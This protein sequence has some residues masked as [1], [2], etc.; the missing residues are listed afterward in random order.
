MAGMNI[1]FS[2]I[3]YVSLIG[4]SEIVSDRSSCYLSRAQFSLLLTCEDAL[5][6]Q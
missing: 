4:F 1:I 2:S 6:M 5:I 3:A